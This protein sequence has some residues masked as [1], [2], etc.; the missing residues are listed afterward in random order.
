M[1]YLTE[2]LEKV[3]NIGQRFVESCIPQNVNYQ[4]WFALLGASYLSWKGL[5]LL[6]FA[7]TNFIRPR[8]DLLTRYGESS[9]VVVVGASGGLGR[10]F[11]EA[12][13]D[14]GFNIILVGRNRAK[15]ELTAN[16]IHKR[17]S[18]TE[19]RIIVTDLREAVKGP[20]FAEDI[21][22]QVEELDISVLVNSV[23]LPD[24][25]YF[26]NRTDKSL[27]EELTVNYFAPVFLSKRFV[28][29]FLTRAKRSAVINVSADA[30]V[31]P[32][33]YTVPY[34][35]SKAFLDSFTRCFELE[36]RDK[37]DVVSVI[38]DV[39][40][41]NLMF[42][43]DYTGDAIRPEQCAVAVLNSLGYEKQTEGHWKHKIIASAMDSI[44][45]G[46]LTKV[47]RRTGPHYIEWRKVQTQR[48]ASGI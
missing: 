20:E 35:P 46:I 34:S 31:R 19:T 33:P 11:C 43:Q 32:T 8:K 14:A 41:T 17:N 26:H 28:S 16:F 22:N 42:N 2:G 48:T 29:R 37:I 39:L 4:K 1:P 5:K 27:V 38:P 45:E 18:K 40:H 25:D 10:A 23:A 6:N 7:Y 47:F 44:P 21:I 3:W 15:L 36:V 13:S 24:N 12:F 30:G 9:W